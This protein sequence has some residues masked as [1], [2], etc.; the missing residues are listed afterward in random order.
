[1]AIIE[2]PAVM[3]VPIVIAVG[4]ATEAQIEQGRRTVADRIAETV[5]ESTVAGGMIR[6]TAGPG[7]RTR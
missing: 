5:V 6:G 4:H 3:E 7:E 1:M 2:V